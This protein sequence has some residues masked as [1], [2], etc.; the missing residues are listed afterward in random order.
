MYHYIEKFN[1]NLKYFSYL[2]FKNFE[3]QIIYFKKKYKFF[4][5]NELF[6]SNFKKKDFSKK[7]FLTFDD[8]LLCHYKYAYKILKK[9]NING[10]FYIPSGPIVD[11]K[12]LP[13]HKIH[14]ILGKYGGEKAYKYLKYK[15]VKNNFVDI[16][17]IKYF[18]N[19]LYLNQ[20][21]SKKTFL[22]KKILNYYIDEKKKQKI[23]NQLFSYFFKNKEKYYFDKLYMKKKHLK[24]LADNNMVIGAHSHSHRVL[25]S[26]NKRDYE[27]DISSSLKFLK[28]FSNKKT[29]SYPYGGFHT[30]NKNIKGYLKKK[31]VSFS[32]NVEPRDITY[33]DFIY[34]KYTLPRYDC[35]KFIYGKIARI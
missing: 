2:D 34:K 4:D 26:L 35:N 24:E 6:E 14:L 18:E 8:G 9:H 11:Q 20:K 12:I 33:N 25:S 23:V 29:F 31:K 19:K 22:F 27:N 13:V 10:I 17:K 3:K 32:M 7:I 16:K 5:C 30:F 21:S 1:P 28:N 15:L